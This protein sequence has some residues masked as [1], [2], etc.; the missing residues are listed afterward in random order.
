MVVE[1][2][3]FVT[4]FAVYRRAVQFFIIFG[5]EPL[6][7]SQK[8]VNISGNMLNHRGFFCA[9]ER[10]HPSE[11]FTVKENDIIGVCLFGQSEQDNNDGG[12]N[13]NVKRSTATVPNPLN[14]LAKD[15]SGYR[16]RQHSSS[17][18]SVGFISD[19]SGSNLFDHALHV[20]VETCKLHSCKKVQFTLQCLH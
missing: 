1:N 11:Y 7:E 6:R 2:E 16:L 9:V 18:S 20:F 15:A 4:D 12:D 10:L 17:C 5:Y 3:R 14:V 13:S 19:I 8:R